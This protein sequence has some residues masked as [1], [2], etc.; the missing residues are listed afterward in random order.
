[1]AAVFLDIEKTFDITW[2]LGLLYEL[3]E[4]KFSICLVKLS[5]SFLSQRKFRISVKGEMS[6]PKDIQAGVPQG[7]VLTTHC[8]LYIQIIRPKH[9]VS[10]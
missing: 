4:L 7:S 8:T 10:I 1:M 6:K 9:L 3:W 5:S 2:H